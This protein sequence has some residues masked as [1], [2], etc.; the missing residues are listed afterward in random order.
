MFRAVPWSPSGGQ[1][2]LLQQL[3]SSISLNDCIVR[4][5]RADSEQSLLSTGLLYSR[6]QRVTIPDSVIIKFDLLKMTMVLL[7][8]C[9]GL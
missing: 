6:L 2:V 9:R 1:I 5:L 3:V 4:M 8:T 7:E